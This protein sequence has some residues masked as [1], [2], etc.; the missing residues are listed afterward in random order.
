MNTVTGLGSYSLEFINVGAKGNLVIDY[1]IVNNKLRENVIKLKVGKRVDS[2]HML[3][4][5]K[6]E[7]E[8][9]G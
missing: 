7:K 4:Y 8:K 9:D 2:D 6:L 5:L 1:V 3:L